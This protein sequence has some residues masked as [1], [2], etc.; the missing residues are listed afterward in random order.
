MKVSSHLSGVFSSQ[1][2]YRSSSFL[3]AGA[4]RGGAELGAA[5]VEPGKPGGAQDGGD[6]AARPDLPTREGG[7]VQER[8]REEGEC[9][10]D[11]KRR[12]ERQREAVQGD[13]EAAEKVGGGGGAVAPRVARSSLS[14][15]KRNRQ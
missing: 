4:D 13:G 8:R 6:G 9:I 1:T 10:L 12:R 15:E 7:G 5:G 2:H 11:F 3:L 14:G